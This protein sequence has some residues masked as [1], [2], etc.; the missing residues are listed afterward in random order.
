MVRKR[1]GLGSESEM[2]SS[3]IGVSLLSMISSLNWLVRVVGS[4][5]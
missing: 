3:V 4:V 5:S 2:W 1:V